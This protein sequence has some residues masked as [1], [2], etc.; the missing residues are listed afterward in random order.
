MARAA[1]TIDPRRFT[2][3]SKR[4]GLP[5]HHADPYG[6]GGDRSA[7]NIRLSASP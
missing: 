6:L 1:E 4:R 7:T 5:F 3:R 2:V